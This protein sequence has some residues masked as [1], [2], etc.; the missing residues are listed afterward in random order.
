[1]GKLMG[2]YILHQHVATEGPTSVPYGDEYKMVFQFLQISHTGN[3]CVDLLTYCK[4]AWSQKWGHFLI[5]FRVTLRCNVMYFMLKV[6]GVKPEF[7]KETFDNLCVFRSVM[8]KI[9]VKN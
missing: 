4:N 8:L 9:D 3:L 7:A 2:K 5:E 1:M 6:D